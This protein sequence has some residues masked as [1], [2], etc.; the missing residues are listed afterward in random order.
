MAALEDASV[1]NA[2]ELKHADDY[3]PFGS[4]ISRADQQHI[5]LAEANLVLGP[6]ILPVGAANVSW[7]SKL[8]MI[9][10][11]KRT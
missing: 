5:L 1:Q 11:Q 3:L 2:S 8:K 10:I 7:H 6:V 4:T 9:K